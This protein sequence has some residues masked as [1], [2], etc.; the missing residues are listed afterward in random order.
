MKTKY[1]TLGLLLALSLGLFSG[2]FHFTATDYAAKALS[3]LFMNFLQMISVPIVFLSITATVTKMESLSEMKSFGMKIIKYTLITT[4][5]AATIALLLYLGLDPAQTSIETSNSITTTPQGGYLD[6]LQKIV[7]SNLFQAFGENNVIGVAFFAFVLS[8]AILLLPKNN[9]E[10]L[11]HFFSSLFSAFLKLAGFI[12]KLLPLAIWAFTTLLVQDLLSKEV[13]FKVLGLYIACIV[14]ANLIQGVVVLPLILLIKKN[15]PRKLFKAMSEALLIAFFTKS[16]NAALPVSMKCAEEKYGM[17]SKVC[18]ISFPLCSVINMNACAAF[19]LITT[20]FVSA[21]S[22]MT[23]S[24]FEL[25]GWVLISTVAAIGNAGVPMGCYFLSTA[26][27]TSMGVPLHIMGLILPIYAFLD[28]LETAINVW[29]DA[30][31]AANVDK[32]IKEAAAVEMA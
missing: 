2:Y 13:S 1:T 6:A 10:T 24:P 9:K 25:L 23:F 16:S 26:L 29:S 30:C 3:S 19:I 27:L 17:S 12:V 14:G 4:L 22:G 7:P 8:F 31:I 32:E 20:L 11:H 21:H 15:S 18:S 5:I 28:M